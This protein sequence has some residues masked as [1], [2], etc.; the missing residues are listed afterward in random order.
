MR[1][2]LKSMSSSVGLFL[3]FVIVT[4]IVLF[5]LYYL[6]IA[7]LQP[8]SEVF[9][10]GMKLVFDPEI[11]GLDNYKLLFTYRDGIYFSWFKNSVLI[12]GLFTILSLFL[13]SFVGY[14]LG[15]YD[16]KF[17]NLIFTM[18]LLVMM[19]PLEILMLPLYKLTVQFK[20]INTYAGVILPFVVSPIAIFFFRQFAS[21]ISEDYLD[22]GRIDGCT[23]IGIYFRIMVPLMKPAFGAMTILL[24]MQNWNSFVW[25]LIVLR[26]NEMF[27][28]TIGLS[29]LIGPYGE[30]FDVMIA[31][32]VL[33]VIPVV[34]VFLFNQRFFIAGLTAGG[35]KG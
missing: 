23:E 27:T 28:L 5:P 6:V 24:A 15:L 17:K 20:I 1:D 2:N 7:S 34:I 22:A 13:S 25:P 31:G 14:G 29:S 8:S 21:G 4:I 33:A 35:V 12:A 9:R 19:V 32:A 16:F 11:M 10:T 3:F 26:T 30:N 18:V